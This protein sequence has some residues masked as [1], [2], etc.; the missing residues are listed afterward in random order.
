MCPSSTVSVRQEKTRF[1][2][3]KL[4]MHP[5]LELLLHRGCEAV[6]HELSKTQNTSLNAFLQTGTFTQ[7]TRILTVKA[8]AVFALYI[9]WSVIK[10]TSV[11]SAT[12]GP[13][14][15]LR[16]HQMLHRP[17]RRVSHKIAW[18]KLLLSENKKSLN[19][20]TKTQARAV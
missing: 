7:K 4:L 13:V 16:H 2:F 15:G 6:L 11:H 9:F 14:T 17:Q 19:L 8:L 18:H 1:S 12:S 20:F 10:L 3:P 5:C